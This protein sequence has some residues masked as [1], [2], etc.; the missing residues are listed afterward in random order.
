M[1]KSFLGVDVDP[2]TLKDIDKMT[3][4]LDELTKEL[5][6]TTGRKRTTKEEAKIA[7][8]KKD[9]RKVTGETFRELYGYY[10]TE[11]GSS[12]HGNDQKPL[13]QEERR[14][15]DREIEN[16]LDVTMNMIEKFATMSESESMSYL[17]DSIQSIASLLGG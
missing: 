12:L 14:Q 15:L 6:A 1:L 5:R 2:E 17:N 9:F 4:L 13:T 8:L 11:T 3:E 16:Q 10:D 7:K